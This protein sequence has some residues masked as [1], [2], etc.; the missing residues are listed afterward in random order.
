[1]PKDRAST[2][3]WPS[4][5]GGGGFVIGAAGPFPKTTAAPTTFAYTAPTSAPLGSNG[6]GGEHR[7]FMAWPAAATTSAAKSRLLCG[8]RV[9]SCPYRRGQ[10]LILVI[11]GAKMAPPYLLA[12]F[13]EELSKSQPDTLLAGTYLGMAA[14]VS[15]T[16]ELVSKVAFQLCVPCSDV[17]AS[18]VAEAASV[19]RFA[20]N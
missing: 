10:K 18:K 15:V 2:A 13:Q 20:G 17:V 9:Q 19:H 7:T 6:G 8:F 11:R 16:P 12:N 3:Q 4:Y 14:R 5:S 1:V